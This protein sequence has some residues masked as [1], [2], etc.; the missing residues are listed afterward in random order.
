MIKPTEFVNELDQF[1]DFYT[2]VPDSLLKDFCA[3]LSDHKSER[4]HIIAANEGNSIGLAAGH[5]LGSGKPALVYMQNSGIG[6]TV[7][8]LLSLTDS[9]VYRIPVLL[10]IGWRGE[11]GK[12]DEPQHV[13]QGK[14]TTSLLECMGIDYAVL[15][16]DSDYRDV[17][18]KARICLDQELPFAI[19]V[20]KGAFEAY[21]LKKSAED[22]SAFSRED[23]LDVILEH[24]EE[25]D[26]FVSTTGKISRELFELRERRR[27]GHTRDFLIVGSMGH[28]SQIAAGVAL[29]RPEKRVYCVDGDGSVLMHMGSLAVNASVA[30]ENM[31]HIVLNNGSHDTVGGQPTAASFLNLDRIASECGYKRCFSCSSPDE[32]VKALDSVQNIGALSLIEV[33]VKKGSRKELGRPTVTP[34][35][36]KKAFMTALAV[37]QEQE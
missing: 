27:Q 12:K 36:C 20:K 4:Q 23:A 2:G 29:S 35:E 7:N 14:I 28:T 24:T 34:V 26:F 9:D 21:K 22:L 17:I 25:S 18:R 11:P 1:I 33:R 15:D 10:L 5:Y 19:V 16:G 30:P 6:N 3:C 32:L 13:K 31:V 8:P 37:E